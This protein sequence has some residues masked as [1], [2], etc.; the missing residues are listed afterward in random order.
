MRR[1]GDPG[2]EAGRRQPAVGLFYTVLPIENQRSCFNGC[3][4]L[5]TDRALESLKLFA[6]YSRCLGP[7]RDRAASL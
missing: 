4:S 1:L 5:G 3:F 7:V 2:G 6:A